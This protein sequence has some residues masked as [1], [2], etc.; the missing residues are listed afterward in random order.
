M[1]KFKD[2]EG[3]RWNVFAPPKFTGDTMFRA[4]VQIDPPKETTAGGLH[5]AETYQT[6]S[7]EGVVLDL[8]HGGYG[9][10]IGT[11]VAIGRYAG[12]PLGD[13]FGDRLKIVNYEEIV[14]VQPLDE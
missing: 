11:R 2:R 12:I 7:T 3:R 8:S 9:L 13:E 4:I 14:L 6:P 1:E 10:E 5:K